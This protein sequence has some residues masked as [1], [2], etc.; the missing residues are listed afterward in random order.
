MIIDPEIYPISSTFRNSEPKT[1]VFSNLEMACADCCAWVS[2]AGWEEVFLLWAHYFWVIN[3]S[4]A[5][6]EK[7]EVDEAHKG[8]RCRGTSSASSSPESW[9]SLSTN[10]SY[11]GC[12][13]IGPNLEANG[14][15]L[16]ASVAKLEVWDEC[17]WSKE[18][19]RE[20]LE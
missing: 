8:W 1:A 2:R 9:A 13:E 10:S 15:T 20:V 16:S 5:A 18:E 19:G 11:K 4:M 3:N 6:R 14:N 12:G 7:E 17:S